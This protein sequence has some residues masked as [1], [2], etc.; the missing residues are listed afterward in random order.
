VVRPHLLEDLD[1]RGGDEVGVEVAERREVLEDDGDH[2]VEE[3]E[4]SEDLEVR[5][6]K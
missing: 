6:Q 1:V 3:D 5:S 4:G 2:E